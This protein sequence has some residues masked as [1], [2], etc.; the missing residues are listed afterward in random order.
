MRKRIGNY[1]VI[2]EIGRGGMAVVYKALHTSLERIV[3]IKE[4]HSSLR[5]D[6]EIIER[7]K[8]EAKAAASLNHSNIV[9]VYDFWNDRNTY[10]LAMEFID[11][12]DLKIILERC[13]KL[14]LEIALI[15]A[16][17]IC[18]AIDF[19]HQRKIIHRDIKTGNIILSRKGAVKLADFG[20]AYIMDT[21]GSNLT[22]S[23]IVLGTPAYMSPEQVRGE[24][25][26]EAS[27]IFSFG[28]VL[29]EMLTG[30]KPFVEDTDEKVIYKILT[31]KPL[32]PRRLN[33][34]IPFRIQRI[35]LKSLQ[36]KP[37]KRYKGMAEVR[38]ALI[39]CAATRKTAFED[40]LKSYIDFALFKKTLKGQAPP[41]ERRG[42]SFYLPRTAKIAA[43][44]ILGLLLVS[45]FLYTRM[46]EVKQK[47]AEPPIEK[48]TEVIQPPKEER[49][50]NTAVVSET[51]KK[52]DAQPQQT[53]KAVQKEEAEKKE[54]ISAEKKDEPSVIDKLKE[55]AGNVIEQKEA[56][57]SGGLRVMAYPWAKVYVD[58]E[59]VETTP[60]SKVIKVPAGEHKITFSHPNFPSV[61]RTVVIKENE[62]RKIVVKLEQGQEKK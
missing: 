41:W 36:K 1:D 24:K 61:T 39:R 46:I 13:E 18:D 22:Q 44:G 28:I 7:F 57:P 4:L 31:K 21:T 53:N 34:N 33:N 37:A 56:V 35:I 62:V 52:A 10:Y 60:T 42:I 51:E 3:A 11:G 48:K 49:R 20:I 47:G 23:G 54:E 29:Y 43:A 19:A 27:D 5:D 55:M 2:E 17:Q 58:G 59:Y 12:I 14:P 9:Q 8:R 32:A 50:P 45:I 26:T 40:V 38:D 15:I 6:R 16:I 30:K 25:L